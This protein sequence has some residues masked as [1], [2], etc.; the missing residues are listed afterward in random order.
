MSLH[1]R[2]EYIQANAK[3]ACFLVSTFVLREREREIKA[4]THL[5]VAD[6]TAVK[7]AT[8][9]SRELLAVQFIS[10]LLW[11]IALLL[12][13]KKIPS[14]TLASNYLPRPRRV[15]VVNY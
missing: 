3:G 1:M 13:Y 6:V 12:A 11:K 8:G 9:I 2:C 7:A 4:L 5:V 10:T 15:L 14:H